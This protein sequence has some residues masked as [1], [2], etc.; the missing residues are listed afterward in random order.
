[1]D[2]NGDELQQAHRELQQDVR[3]LLVL[4]PINI[5]REQR[6][7]TPRQMRC[8]LMEHQKVCL[9]W[10][11]RQEEDR[12]K[13][14]GLLADGMG[15]GKTIQALALIVARPSSDGARKTTLIVA[16]LALLRQWQSEIETKIKPQ[17][18]LK[19]I[20]FHG[21]IKGT[22]SV[23]EVLDHDIV[24]CTYGKLTAE[25]KARF[26]LNKLKGVAI[27]HPQSL[28][29]RVILDEAHN[30][31][32]KSTKASLAAAAIQSE[33]RLCM[34]GTPFMNRAAEI[35]PLI[36]FLRIAPYDRW[37]RFS[38]EIDRP[39]QKW[40]GDRGA[41]ALRKLQAVIRSITIRRTKESRLD[42]QPIIRLPPRREEDAHTQFDPDQAA[43]YHALECQQRLKFNKYLKAGTVLK[44][45]IYV[46]VLLLRLR[47][48]CD[49]PHLIKNHGTP[50]G[51][52]LGADE[53]LALALKLKPD[54]VARIK[55]QEQF[56]CPICDAVPE[57]AVIISPCGHSIC[58]ECFA[59]GMSV[60][61]TQDDGGRQM[62]M[63]CPEPGCRVLVTG[64]NV[65]MHNFFNYLSL[66]QLRNDAFRNAE[67]MHRYRRRLRKEWVSSAKIDKI[68]SLLADIRRHQPRE[69]TLIFSLWTS[70]LDLLEVPIQDVGFG[71]TRYD[72][73]MRPDTRD[74]A[75]KN[76]ME[77]PDVEV[78]LVSLTAGNAGLNL[79]A[80][81]QV[82]ISEPFWN[83]FTEEQAIDRAHRIGQMR[84]V[85]VHRV[86][87]AGTVEDRILALQSKKKALV[88]AALSE[89]GASYTGRLSIEELQ[90]L[91]GV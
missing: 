24:L 5:P 67:A 73:S 6:V 19:T 62:E 23:D 38:E 87:I 76:F 42:G 48:A 82:I 81:S 28:F 71:Y 50:E 11:M 47:Q 2:A 61:E 56:E 7:Q 20:V 63:K 35:Y 29:Y 43:F 69:K 46:L 55:A 77:N 78:M 39:I 88:N 16:P 60:R 8:Q 58:P 68:M 33:Y 10:L 90:S 52:S 80:A 26:E 79:T 14:G 32:N 64:T 84:R 49:H 34:T 45:Y 15:L 83:P 36:R 85:T 12:N 65:V 17:Y 91:F 9:S 74:A 27:L 3:N 21:G 51:T 4:P 18:Q 40:D 53:M 1:M 30:I 70:F 25:Y 86:L 22:T 37:E 41:A 59:L 89:E 57:N 75:V 66:G 72:G 44:N 54:V 31:K 13:R